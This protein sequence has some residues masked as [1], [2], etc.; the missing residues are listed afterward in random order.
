MLSRWVRKILKCKH[1]HIAYHPNGGKPCPYEPVECACETSTGCSIPVYDVLCLDC[2]KT[3]LLGDDEV[4]DFF[5][6][7]IPDSVPLDIGSIRTAL[8]E[9][10]GK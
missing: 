4:M 3:W 2:G 7:R 5:G 1:R 9:R 10:K 6:S 8:K